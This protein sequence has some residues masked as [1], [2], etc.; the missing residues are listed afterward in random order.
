M[1]YASRDPR[2][3]RDKADLG[4]FGLGLKLASL[5]QCRKLTVV[6]RKGGQT[7]AGIWDQSHID[8]TKEW[9]LLLPDDPMSVPYADRLGESGTVVLW[10]DIDTLEEA[11]DRQSAGQE[12]NRK[13]ND[14]RSHLELVFHR[15]ISGERG[16]TKCRMT[17]NNDPL[18]PFEP[19]HLNHPATQKEDVQKISKD[20]S[21]QVFTLPHHSKVTKEEWRR[22]EGKD[23]YLKSQGLYIYREKRL[24]IH[25][26]WLRVARQ[27]ELTKLTRVKIDIS[28]A[29]DSEWGITLDKSTANLPVTVRQRL[30]NLIERIGG[31][32]KRVYT[33]RGQ[34]LASESMLPAWNRV[35]NK[36]QISFEINTENPLVDSFVQSLPEASQ[37]SFRELL[38]FVASS[39]PWDALYAVMGDDP[40]EVGAAVADDDLREWALETFDSLL[41][42]A[43][44][45]P[46]RAADILKMM[47]PFRSHWDRTE[48]ILLTERNV[49]V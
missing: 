26:T 13:L 37:K 12:F 47:E 9:D 35:Q 21:F 40:T 1:T 23:G 30:R 46:G 3:A 28:N 20:V 44:A 42:L 45:D 14:S 41:K 25:G 4:R 17:L 19:F 49:D 16:L 33:K 22:Y 24:I 15:F 8:R 6:T 43:S 32:S 5:S 39:L 18:E 11:G 27:T 29:V 31:T 2:D 48:H 34:R 7:S 38:R 36:G 10:R